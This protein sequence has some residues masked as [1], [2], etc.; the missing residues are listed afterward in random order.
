[1]SGRRPFKELTKGWPADRRLRVERRKDELLREI[2]EAALADLRKA[3]HVSQE[4]LARAL[5]K[6]QAAVAQMERRADMKIS[7]LRE[8]IEAMGGKLELVARFPAGE[9]RITRLGE[10]AD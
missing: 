1:M 2:E 6:S 8:T 3:L 10:A 5:G 4:E 9:V 7:T